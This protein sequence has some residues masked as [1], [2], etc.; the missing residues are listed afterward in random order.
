MNP[1]NKQKLLKRLTRTIIKHENDTPGKLARVLYADYFEPLADPEA[2]LKSGAKRTSK[3]KRNLNATMAEALGIAVDRAKG[4]VF[5]SRDVLGDDLFIKS[6]SKLQ[7]WG[8]IEKIRHGL[9][10][11]TSKGEAFVRY[12]DPSYKYVYVSHGRVL[13]RSREAVRFKD[14]VK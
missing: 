12:N 4:E 13:Y 6:F 1:A 10:K 9:W 7:Y 14:L 2:F 8:F 11:V 3:H 5:N